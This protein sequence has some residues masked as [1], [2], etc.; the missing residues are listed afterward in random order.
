MVEITFSA[1]RLVLIATIDDIVEEY[2]TRDLVDRL[3]LFADCDV[4]LKR[5]YH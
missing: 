5:S 4:N 3:R 1:D 2:Q